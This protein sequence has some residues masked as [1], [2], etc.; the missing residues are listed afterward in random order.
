MPD[1][2]VADLDQMD[3]TVSRME[4]F[5]NQ[6]QSWLDEI[7]HE[8]AKLHL[9]WSGD[10]ASAQKAD[11][12]RWTKDMQ[13]AKAALESLKTVMRQAHTNYQGANTANTAMWAG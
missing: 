6:V 2:Y 5:E 1:R 4:A 11:H 3:S 10:A 9:T 8:I 7:D 13:D 12:D